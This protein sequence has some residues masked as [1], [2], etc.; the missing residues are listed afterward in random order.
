MDVKFFGG[1]DEEVAREIIELEEVAMQW[2]NSK[3]L[4]EI[5]VSPTND[6]DLFLIKMDV[7][8]R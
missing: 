8:V 7:Q 3:T 1:S 2:W 5:L 4:M 6:W